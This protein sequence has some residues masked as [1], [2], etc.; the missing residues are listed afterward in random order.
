MSEH[1]PAPPTP[2][3][4]AP[5]HGTI[6]IIRESRYAD[7]IRAYKIVLNGQEAGKV[8]NGDRTYLEVPA[9]RHQIQFRIDWGYSQ[10]LE[11]DV[12]AGGMTSVS[13]CGRNPF[14]ALYYTTFGRNK[15]VDL[16]M[17]GTPR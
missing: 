5:G 15:Y 16:W 7:R 17:T 4:V 11:F 14:T 10:I 1:H 2:Y 6:E 12:P 8:R 9:G 13:C 3:A